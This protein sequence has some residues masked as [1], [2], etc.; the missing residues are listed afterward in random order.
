MSKILV[1]DKT[2]HVLNIK[3]LSSLSK[4]Q[5]LKITFLFLFTNKKIFGD[6]VFMILHI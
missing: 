2:I 6:A 3:G 5:F 4:Y 1:F